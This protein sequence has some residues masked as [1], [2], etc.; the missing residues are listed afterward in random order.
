MG[1]ELRTPCRIG[2]DLEWLPHR[3][4]EQEE[5]VYQLFR[6]CQIRGGM[7]MHCSLTNSPCCQ[8]VSKA[9]FTSSIAT[10]AFLPL[11]LIDWMASCRTK[12]V[13]IGL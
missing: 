3:S 6:T 5:E 13:W 12:A 1:I 11:S 9:F 7:P 4:T 2:N 10:Y 8:T